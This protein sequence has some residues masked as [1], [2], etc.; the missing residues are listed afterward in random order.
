MADRLITPY[1]SFKKKRDFIL[2]LVFSS[3]IILI[4]LIVLNFFV[5][6]NNSLIEISLVLFLIIFIGALIFVRQ[7]LF[8]INM[9][10]HFYRMIEEN[11]PAFTAKVMPFEVGF[12]NNLKEYQFTLGIQQTDYQIFYR[13]Y[14]RLPWVER[15]QPT[16]VVIVLSQNPT[17]EIDS[18][19][20]EADLTSIKD[21]LNHQPQ[22][23]NEL[24]LLIKKHENLTEEIKEKTHK[25]INFVYQNRAIVSIPCVQLNDRRM[26]VLRPKKLYPNKYYYVLIKLLYYLTEADEML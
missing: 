8:S 12:I 4:T 26:Y 9:Y 18:T 5:Y 11:Q 3:L 25:I 15:T 17:L 6:R 13:V 20:L 21:K 2:S 16:L 10:L 23:Q 19:S 1:K 24:T 7:M 22:V 14:R